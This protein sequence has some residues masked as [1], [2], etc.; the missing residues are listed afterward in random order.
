MIDL[1]KIGAE[2]A[3]KAKREAVLQVLEEL[4][5]NPQF[6]N[7]QK[8]IKLMMLGIEVGCTSVTVEKILKELDIEL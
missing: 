2:A 6:E 1:K 7:G 5:K 8:T 3:V 4:R